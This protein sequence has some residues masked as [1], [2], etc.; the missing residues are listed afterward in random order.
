ME[1]T[2]VTCWYLFLLT[3]TIQV[4]VRS[5]KAFCGVLPSHDSRGERKVYS[6]TLPFQLLPP[7]LP[8]P[9][10]P[11]PPHPYPLPIS[12]PPTLSPSLPLPPSPHPYPSHPLPIP[13]Y[14]SSSLFTF[15]S[16]LSSVL[17]FHLSC[18]VRVE[19]LVT[20]EI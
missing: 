4:C 16:P 14:L 13:C 12:T 9:Y 6:S 2:H 7:V 5:C 3:A 11:T 20:T 10:P 15:P 19:G 8:H 1:V 18:P 17:F